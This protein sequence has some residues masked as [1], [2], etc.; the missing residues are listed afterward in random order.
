MQAS[1]DA[2]REGKRCG[3]YFFGTVYV[4]LSVVFRARGDGEAVAG[5][6]DHRGQRQAARGAGEVDE[7]RVS[8]ARCAPALLLDESSVLFID[9]SSVTG[10]SGCSVGGAEA[11]AAGWVG[12]ELCCVGGHRQRESETARVMYVP[13]R[14]L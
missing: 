2:L 8:I 4:I 13:W 7:M 11:G 14:R 3:H 1:D 5:A 12:C 9:E 6:S 10:G